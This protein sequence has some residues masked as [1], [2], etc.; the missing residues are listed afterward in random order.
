MVARNKFFIR[1]LCLFA[2]CSS[3]SCKEDTKV[4]SILRNRLGVNA[5]YDEYT[6]YFPLKFKREHSNDTVWSVV[7][8][9]W[10]FRNSNFHL[11]DYESFVEKVITDVDKNGFLTVDSA[12]F[13]LCREIPIVQDIE[14]DSL[15]QR[16]GI[17]GI[18]LN[19]VNRDRALTASTPQK[20]DYLIFLLYRHHIVCDVIT[21]SN[22][23]HV[24]F[25][26]TGKEEE[27][28]ELLMKSKST[29]YVCPFFVNGMLDSLEIQSS[30][31]RKN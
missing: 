15:Y 8:G 28:E 10:L 1:V 3:I 26:A 16:E 29:A 18:L 31:F 5:S 23:V 25:Y 4:I 24:N 17:N 19:Y 7:E 30:L 12:C 2:L 21:F 14:I 9:K 6:D 27:Y 13:E 11:I 20:L 22:V